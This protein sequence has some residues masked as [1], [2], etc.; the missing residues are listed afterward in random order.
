MRIA[1]LIG[2]LATAARAD[3]PR[4]TFFESR[5]R[6][7]LIEKCQSCHGAKLQQGGLRV[8]SL[9]AL[10]R[11]GKRGPALTRGKAADS[12]L[13]QAVQQRG[14][15]KMPFGGAK[16]PDHEVTALMT[17]INA[18]AVWPTAPASRLA[19]TDSRHW[20][21]APVKAYELPKTKDRSWPQAPI[22]HFLLAKLEVRGLRPAPP[23]DRR[24][25]LR[26]A[27]FD[28]T[29]LP[30]TLQE[31]DLFLADQ[32]PQAFARV[33]N[34]LLESPRYGERWGRKWLDSVRYAD[35]NGLDENY[36]WAHI[37]R[38]RD[39]VIDAFN[40]D[41]PFDDFI[42]EQIA[43][44]RL[45]RELE[46]SDP[47]RH[48]LLIA[49][50]FLM[51][52]PKL[53]ANP[54]KAKVHLDI[55]DEQIDALSRSF[56]AVTLAC[57]RCHDHK[58]D[59]FTSRD[60]YALAGIFHSTRTMVDF[61][62]RTWSERPLADPATAARSEEHEK[63]LAARRAS[64][65]SAKK[66]K[67]TAKVAKLE[68]EVAELVRTAPPEVPIAMAVMDNEP[69]DLTT[70]IRGDHN[71]PGELVAR[72]VPAVLAGATPPTLPATVSGR[73]ELARWIASPRNPLTARVLVNR[74]WQGH[75]GTGLVA[76]SDNFGKLGEPP[77]HP[78]LLDWLA[79][80]FL[81]A[82]WSV[83]QLHR[84][85]MLSATYQMSTTHDAR[86]AQ[87][88]PENRLLW[89]MPRRRL[90]AEELRDAVLA[91]SGSLDLT[92]GGSLMAD[93]PNMQRVTTD[94][95]EDF[96]QKAYA[97]M[98]RSVYV[99]V[100]RNALFPM[101]EL[102]DVADP[103]AVTPRRNETIVAPQALLLLNNPQVIELAK[104]WAA[105][106]V[107]LG[108]DEARVRAAYLQAFARPATAAEVAEAVAFIKPAPEAWPR[109]CQALLCTNEFVYVE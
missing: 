92:M 84:E 63:V 26:R 48:R 50:G 43:G 78:E 13:I 35:S 69:A 46:P 77:S 12:L 108:P 60:Y 3:D 36:H 1:L 24:A 7:V 21:F 32:S 87:L 61:V 33:V 64:L 81:A 15:L 103:S 82:G 42:V 5:V 2:L 90:E 93:V 76:T 52:G 71:K 59:P 67:E 58:F 80:K 100:I 72:G 40:R 23:A 22:D 10:L 106:L 74:V 97:T 83:K 98:R 28:L 62:K 65:E 95:S 99:P 102:F 38:Y 29:G 34:R 45:A 51:C 19:N 109:F 55:I 85:L 57:A 105:E 17:W 27:T 16:L 70:F 37:W 20:A 101:L 39:Y 53:S 107:R 25:L 11:G 49:T 47:E 8:D 4:A 91:L 66:K 41:L 75:F 88:D 104:R 6:P 73:L 54:D 68:A 14:D 56:L 96:G 44:D 79:Q 9:E 89:R 30:P 94:Q 18:G 31:Q 86:A